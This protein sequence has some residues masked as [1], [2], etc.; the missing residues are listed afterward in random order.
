MLLDRQMGLAFRESQH[1]GYPMLAG[2]VANGELVRG[3]HELQ[4]FA[5][6]EP[7]L[8][9]RKV[10]CWRDADTARLA[11]TKP[12]RRSRTL[13]Y[14]TVRWD[15]SLAIRNRIER[16]REKVFIVWIVLKDN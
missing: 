14:S 16:E 4:L 15:G 7:F 12:V 10:S 8:A 6:L 5:Q 13:G 1:D 3:G 2:S 9:E 11:V